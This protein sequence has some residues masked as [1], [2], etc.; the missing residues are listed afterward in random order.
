MICY[1]ISFFPVF[2]L[3]KWEHCVRCIPR[4]F[5]VFIAI[6]GGI[7]LYYIF[8]GTEKCIRLF[9]SL[10]MILLACCLSSTPFLPLSLILLFL[11]KIV[12][13]LEPWPMWLNWLEHCPV[14]WKVTGSIPSQGTCLA[15]VT[16]ERQLIDVSLWHQYFSPS[17][18][19]CL[20][21]S[22]HV[23]RWG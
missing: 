9:C 2:L 12:Y 13:W 6:V 8:N 16:E 19:L 3:D 14:N 10:L 21:V 15:P 5:K 7:V 4:N 1:F 22:K 23:L 11:K 17:L 20:K 18:P